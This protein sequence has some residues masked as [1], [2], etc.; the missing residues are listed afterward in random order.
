MSLRTTLRT[1]VLTA[2]ATGAVLL[3]TAAA[4][5]DNTPTPVP[6]ASVATPSPT[7][8]PG[9]ASEGAEPSAVPAEVEPGTMPRGGVDAGERSVQGTDHTALYGSAAGA[10]L[11]AGACALVL[12]GRSAARRNG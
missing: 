3:P 5:A 11:L 4:V 10:V 1:A 8:T 9:S 12:R 6:T 2:V 7:P